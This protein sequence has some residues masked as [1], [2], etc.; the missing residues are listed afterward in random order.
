MVLRDVAEA[1]DLHESTVSRVAT[2][3]YIHTPRGVFEFRHFFSSHVNTADGSEISSTAVRAKIKKLIANENPEKP[4]SDSEI[5]EIL[6][7]AGTRVARRTV[8]KYR[9]LMKIA[10]S[11]ERRRTSAP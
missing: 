6:M 4:I 9:E 2:G 1:L 5:A 11:S 10:P 8:A 3:K 7:T